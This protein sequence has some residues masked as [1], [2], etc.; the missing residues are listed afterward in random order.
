MLRQKSNKAFIT[1]ALL[2]L[3]HSCKDML[4]VREKYTSLRKQNSPAVIR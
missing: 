3:I 4:T 2:Q 1:N